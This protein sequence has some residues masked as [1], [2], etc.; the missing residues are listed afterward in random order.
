MNIKRKSF[1]TDG[2]DCL[3]LRDKIEIL[4]SSNPMIAIIIKVNF[5][6]HNVC[7]QNV[8]MD[9]ITS[10][11]AQIYVD[12]EWISRNIDDVMT[13]LFSAKTIDLKNIYAEL[14]GFLDNPTKKRL[15]EYLCNDRNDCEKRIDNKLKQKIK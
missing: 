8:Y 3:S 12:G 5:N 11:S 6:K 15:D 14:K 9:D 13:E 10:N 1:A 2:I 7:H 4:S